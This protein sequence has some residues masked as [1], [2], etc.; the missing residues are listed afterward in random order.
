MVTAVRV[1]DALE[2][3]GSIV[4]NLVLAI[5]GASALTLLVGGFGAGRRARR[6]PPPPG[7]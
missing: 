1:K 2:A 5:R 3:I 6:R 4:A 7:L